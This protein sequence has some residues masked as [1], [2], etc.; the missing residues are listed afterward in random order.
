[1]SDTMT[2]RAPARWTAL[3]LSALGAGLAVAILG[4]LGDASD[5]HLLIAPLG[6]SAVLVFALPASP[7]AQPRAVIGGN[8][9]GAVV[10]LASLSLLGHAPWAL[11]TAVAITLALMLLTRTLHAPAGGMPVLLAD[12]MPD[13]WMFLAAVAAGT[14][15]LVTLGTGYHRLLLR[16]PYPQTWR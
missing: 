7:L 9:I 15:L 6:A 2:T 13:P 14:L 4:F 5:L 3:V 16:Q 8:L 11:G 1:M 12:A 10:A